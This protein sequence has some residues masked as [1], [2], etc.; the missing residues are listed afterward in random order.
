MHESDVSWLWT[1]TFN[2]WL[3][4]CKSLVWFFVEK[5]RKLSSS[6]IHESHLYQGS[7]D[8]RGS[9]IVTQNSI[10]AVSQKFYC[11]GKDWAF[12]THNKIVKISSNTKFYVLELIKL[13]NFPPGST[14]PFFFYCHDHIWLSFTK[15]ES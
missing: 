14:T 6:Y 7:F 4:W 13:L 9:Y 5:T 1:Q 11:N 12:F 8:L 2:S 3:C 15:T 10:I